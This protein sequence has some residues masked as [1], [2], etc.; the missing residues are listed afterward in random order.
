MKKIICMFLIV[1]LIANSIPANVCAADTTITDNSVAIAQ[2]LISDDNGCNYYSQ[3]T[4][5]ID[6]FYIY[7]AEAYLDNK[8]QFWLTNGWT[9]ILNSDY[10]QLNKNEYIYD[11]FIMGFLK[12]QTGNASY[13]ESETNRVKT[14]AENLYSGLSDE[15]KDDAYKE[16]L[17]DPFPESSWR[18]FENMGIAEN[19]D[20]VMK[21][22]DFA[23]MGIED[24]ID[25]LSVN[26]EVLEANKHKIALLKASMDYAANERSD[27]DYTKAMETIVTSLEK[28]DPEDYLFKKTI[29]ESSNTLLQ[30]SEEYIKKIIPVFGAIDLEVSGIDAIFNSS[31]SA[32]YDVKLSY[33]YL[34][35]SYLRNGLYSLRE[36]FQND[37][38]PKNARAFID[39]FKTYLLFQNFG[40]MYA[41]EWLDNYI[42]TRSSFIL[43]LFNKKN[44]ELAESTKEKIELETRQNEEMIHNITELENMEITQEIPKVTEDNTAYLDVLKKYEDCIKSW[45]GRIKEE[46]EW[47]ED[48]EYLYDER[49]IAIADIN[50]DGIDEL[51][52]VANTDAQTHEGW[53]EYVKDL[54]IFTIQDGQASKIFQETIYTEAAGGHRYLIL[55]TT[56]NQLVVLDT[57]IDEFEDCS[58]DRYSI[59][60]NNLSKAGHHELYYNPYPYGDEPMYS[61]NMDGEETTVTEREFEN[62]TQSL[63]KNFETVLIKS[64]GR[65]ELSIYDIQDEQEA[66]SM[67]YEEAVEFLGGNTTTNGGDEP[68]Q[69]TGNNDNPEF[70]SYSEVIHKLKN[71]FGDI[72]FNSYYSQ[73]ESNNYEDYYIVEACGLCYMELIDFNNDG[74]E[75]LLAVAKHPE[76][77]EYTVFIY[78][79]EEG[80]IRELSASKD[81]ICNFDY[82][83]IN[84]RQLAIKTISSQESYIDAGFLGDTY[85]CFKVYGIQNDEF[86]LKS[87]CCIKNFFNENTLD[88]DINYYVMD[89]SFNYSED[90]EHIDQYMVSEDEFK[91]K[92]DDWIYLYD[93]SDKVIPLRDVVSESE[94]QEGDYGLID[95]S[96]LID[97]LI[98]TEE[99]VGS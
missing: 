7:L 92:I 41:T 75:E 99:I 93:Y 84:G 72:E 66:V 91:S 94:L 80:S 18:K 79:A 74:E 10:K 19:L 31:D 3:F 73:D 11:M 70:K 77:D 88:W 53:E 89:E 68:P 20:A 29:N 90:F 49:Q 35:D 52:F 81:L 46:N 98:G 36:Q 96:L 50:G 97:S 13:Q 60:G 95:K 22:I 12:F 4:K 33:L 1:L 69:V 24:L 82:N 9:D 64:G 37:P 63:S 26:T 6:P 32:A 85:T 83:N 16:L 45:E 44:I 55:K 5:H 21:C 57:A 15:L 25:I 14:L 54:Y 47:Y 62:K 58:M 65:I 17:N 71:D 2:M 39:G 43:K 27:N 23:E 87:Y 48:V 76:D 34:I 59:Q 42:Q 30:L 40:D 86:R 38:S 78:T 51:L 61:I 28:A 8:I 56:D 67:T